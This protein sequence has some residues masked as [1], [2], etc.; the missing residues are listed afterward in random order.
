MR[1]TG[2][3]GCSKLQPTAREGKEAVHLSMLVVMPADV[4]GDVQFNR[5]RE[6]P[7]VR[8]RDMQAKPVAKF[9]QHLPISKADIPAYQLTIL[10]Q[11]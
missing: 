8:L 6:R 11:H 3:Q 2:D 9:Q 7:D 5:Q 4:G 10:K 1:T